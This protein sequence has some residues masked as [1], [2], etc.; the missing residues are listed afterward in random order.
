MRSPACSCLPETLRPSAKAIARLIEDR[1]WA[2]R[3]GQQASA[4]AH[5]MLGMDRMVA[6]TEAL[7]VQALGR[8][9]S[10]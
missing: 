5:S 8:A 6:R 3:L 2:A 7:Y 4:Y 10:L 1:A 9:K